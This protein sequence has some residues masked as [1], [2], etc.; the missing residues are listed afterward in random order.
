MKSTGFSGET[1]SGLAPPPGCFRFFPMSQNH[2]RSIH[3]SHC[4]QRFCSSN[5]LASPH[6]VPRRSQLGS[7]PRAA[8]AIL[9][10]FETAS[11]TKFNRLLDETTH[12]VIAIR[13]PAFCRL[14]LRRARHGFRAGRKSRSSDGRVGLDGE[15][16]QR[17]WRRILASISRPSRQ[18]SSIRAS[19][20]TGPMERVG[21]RTLAN[22]H[23]GQGL[24]VT[25]CLGRSN[26]VD[27]RHN[28]RAI[29]V[30]VSDPS[31]DRKD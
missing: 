7:M 11:S 9:V 29:H 23:I 17:G 13:F 15:R 31:A 27:Q 10:G 25:H 21:K 26:L 22:R 3:R 24:V 4:G 18:R 28:G 12:E 6:G 20:S 2:S 8:M 16:S 1:G 30:G 14:V 19:R 5:G